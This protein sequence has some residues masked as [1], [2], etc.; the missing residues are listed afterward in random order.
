MRLYRALLHLYP[1]SFRAEYGEEMCIVF[2]RRQTSTLAAVFE[3]LR[4]APA[5][6]WDV[7]RQDLRYTARTLARAPGFT[8]VAILVLAL[9][10]G[11]N[12]AVF[13]VTDYVL[14]R[15]LPFPSP[16]RL[17]SLWETLPGYRHMELSPANYRDWKRMNIV[18]EDLAAIAT[19]QVNLIGQGAPER[20]KAANVTGNLFTVLGV[21]PLLGRS[22]TPADDRESAP[23]TVVLSYGLWQ[24]AF[25]GEAGVLGRKVDLD[26][27]PYVVIGIMPPQFRFPNQEVELWMPFEFS[28]NAFADR[29]NNY[30]Q[31]VARLRRGVSVRQ[32][33]AEMDVITAQ[34]RR[35]YPK[36]LERT[37]A[38]VDGM[39]DEISEQRRLLLLALAG[40]AL[41]VLLIACSNLA[42]LLLARALSRQKELAVRT[43]LGAGRERLIRQ[44]VTESMV[45]ALLGG[46][47]GVLLA[48]LALPLLTRLVPSLP[49]SGVPSIDFRVLGFAATLTALT[50]IGFGTVPA[51]R[52]GRGD[53][54]GLRE[55]SRSGGG[56]KAGLR[57]A[58]IL[59]EVTLSVVLLIS[60]GLLLRALLRVQS[61]DPGF[62]SDGVLTLETALPLPKYD[63]VARRTAFYG[64]VLADVQALPGVSAAAYISF[65]PMVMG[66]GIWPVDIDGKTLDRSEAHSAS[67]RFVTPGFFSALRIPLQAGRNISASDARD[68]PF[69][70]VVSESLARRYWPGQSPLGR[71]F[72]FG[73]FDRIVVGVVGD[74]RVRGL[75]KNS[76]PQ[77]YL[78]YQQVPDGWMVFYVPKD[79]V[80]HAS[81]NPLLLLPAVRRII[82]DADPEQ[83]ISDVRTLSEIV[84]NDTAPRAV[85]V[86]IIGAFAALAC[87][88]AGLGIHGLLSFTVSNRSS[89][90]AVRIALG[91]QPRDILRIVLRDSLLLATAGVVLGVALAYVAGRAMQALLAG[92][93]PADAATFLAAAGLC[94]LMTLAG[95][96]APSLRALGVDAITA[97]RSE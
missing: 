30:I 33:S 79:L 36:E 84:Q 82:H 26:G 46:L 16:D 60:A 20:L 80:I 49:A 66:G 8:A 50:G 81:G 43:A 54:N 83:P 35:R 4:N 55:G 32:A 70:A 75:E 94:F 24:R 17:V 95:S 97:I 93:A 78:P 68:K 74:I 58:L 42:N 53:L 57:S 2:R 67:L 18:F 59:A 61:V 40:A 12:T 90:I 25:G 77:V 71:H 89:E 56:R 13:S 52:A 6:H 69:V 21:Q 28:E 15:P 9:G 51:L 19:Q 41:C 37:G 65:L 5:V 76:E 7:L 29:N 47:L 91:A 14:I 44:L 88:L 87:L 38:Q 62:R 64:R 27:T 63:S 11:A 10:I 85:Q 31:G 3:V 73:L 34:L 96:L 92:L 86:R 23:L 1:A 72:K 39:R 22:I 48:T 45:L